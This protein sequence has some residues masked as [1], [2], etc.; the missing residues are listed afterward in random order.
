MW[1]QV[2][3][4]CGPLAYAD[5]VT[6]LVKSRDEGINEGLGVDRCST[7]VQG[8]VGLRVEYTFYKTTDNVDQSV[9]MW[10]VGD[11]LWHSK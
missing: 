7:H 4:N 1:P 6:V 11:V 8:S 3:I 2:K 10:G 5:D 9:A